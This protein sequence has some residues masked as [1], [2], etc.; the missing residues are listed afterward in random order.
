MSKLPNLKSKTYLRG[1]VQSHFHP[2]GLAIKEGTAEFPA[3]ASRVSSYCLKTLFL[4]LN[5]DDT[6]AR[7]LGF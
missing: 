6:E 5:P 1:G 3:R 7:F 2:V 4:K